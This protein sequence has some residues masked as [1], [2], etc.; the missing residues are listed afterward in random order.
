LRKSG[1]DL[2]AGIVE[3]RLKALADGM[4]M[5]YSLLIS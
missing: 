3:R 2:A 5:K 1:K 4:N